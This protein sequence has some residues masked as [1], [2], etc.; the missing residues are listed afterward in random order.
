MCKQC[1][2]IDCKS[3]L[4]WNIEKNLYVKNILWHV[5]DSLPLK[6]LFLQKCFS[7]GIQRKLKRLS[8]S[9][10]ISL[11]KRDDLRGLDTVGGFLNH[12]YRGPNFL[13]EPHCK[14]GLLSM[15][16]TV[17]RFWHRWKNISSELPSPCLPHP[18]LLAYV[19]VPHNLFFKTSVQFN[20]VVV[21]LQC[22]AQTQWLSS[23]Q[24]C[25]QKSFSGW[26]EPHSSPL[27][28]NDFA[29]SPKRNQSCH[30]DILLL[31]LHPLCFL[32]LAACRFWVCL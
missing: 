27:F 3:Y 5:D 9:S 23:V 30:G 18:H 1:I 21:S 2:I 15:E 20:T 6:A 29:S 26:E 10:I 8:R 14:S 31:P 28:L 22:S 11:T 16:S 19:S 4:Y 17:D 13:Y 7:I 12:W 32:W 25:V 24:N